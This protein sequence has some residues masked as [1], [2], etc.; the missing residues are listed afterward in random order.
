MYDKMRLTVARNHGALVDR[1]GYNARTGILRLH[2]VR[3]ANWVDR[4]ADRWHALVGRNAPAPDDVCPGPAQC[5]EVTPVPNITMLT[6][7]SLSTDEL[8]MVRPYR[9]GDPEPEVPNI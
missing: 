6:G 2:A 9:T 8:R 5:I 1:N 4:L 3:P 7:T